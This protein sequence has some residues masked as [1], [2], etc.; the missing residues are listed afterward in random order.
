MEI[1]N[2][3]LQNTWW[4]KKE[5]INEDEK[6]TDYYRAKYKIE[7]E[8]LEEY[9]KNT[10]AIITLRGPRQIGK[11][12]A[13]KL[14]IK[15]L[16]LE[17]NIDSKK[18]FF[19]ACDLIRDYKELHE[20]LTVYLDFIRPKFPK[21][22]IYIFLDEISFVHEWQ[23]AIKSL[24]DF[25]K[26][27][28]A[29]ILITGSNL[30]DIKSS[31]ERMPG[32]RGKLAKLDFEYLPICFREFVKILKPEY[33]EMNTE[34]L[35]FKLPELNKLLDDFLITGGFPTSINAFYEK[36]YIPS[37]LY[38]IYTNW[39]E[40]D[41]G[42]IGRSDRTMYTITNKIFDYYTTPIS[43]NKLGKESGNLAHTSISE[44]LDILSK[45]YVLS[46]CHFIDTNSLSEVARKN[47]KIYFTD[48]LIFQCF[49]SKK[50]GINDAPFLQM[51]RSLENPELKSKVIENIVGENLRRIYGN[52]FYNA[53]AKYE[54]DFVTKKLNKLHF[55]EVKY[56]N[57]IHEKEF[58]EYKTH[59]KVNT[60][61]TIITKNKLK[62]DS[63]IN[64]IPASIFLLKLSL[65]TQPKILPPQNF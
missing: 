45:L 63:N 62:N 27:K 39:I 60:L 47:T 64:Y 8:I 29:T 56:R 44:Y 42:K 49:F 51:Q 9:P 21:N 61:L 30:I 36:G 28:N 53:T 25:G 50:I 59:V 3:S 12:T 6:I 20:I 41:I 52:F 15:K 2:L 10:D 55:F 32:R 33:L 5:F 24:A 13:I 37:Y 26:F 57:Q 4:L 31:S 34:E 46:L 1:E 35:Y 23:R 19:L 14:I 65:H 43:F 17:E 54:I 7:H 40:G 38:Q 22:R 16:L 48:P 18:I 58:D 11:S